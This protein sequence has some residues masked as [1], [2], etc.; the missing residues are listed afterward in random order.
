M[1]DPRRALNLVSRSDASPV[2]ARQELAHGDLIGSILVKT[3]AL[4]A[5]D[6]DVILGEQRLGRERFGDIA[7]RLG[8]VRRG[9]LDVAVAKQFEFTQ[10]DPLDTSVSRR[11]ISAFR[12]NSVTGVAIR[13]LRSQL[14]FRWF[15]N[16][17]GGAILA[18][19][20]AGRREGRSFIAANL[21]VSFAQMGRRTLLIDADLR[22]PRQHEW[23][24]LK[25]REGLAAML[26]GHCRDAPITPIA[27]IPGLS[28]L[29]AGTTPPNPQELLA[30]PAF[31]GL[32]GEADEHYSVS[33]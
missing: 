18:V 26:A 27:S 6:V 23:F 31:D 30:R 12:P 17:S 4:K 28:V 10:L 15:A 16:A 9:A 5:A 14:A 3:G 11:I 22:R 13:E 29:P 2:V 33:L 24:K 21:A 1:S 7:R 25:Q 20:G 8:F 32:L 19:V